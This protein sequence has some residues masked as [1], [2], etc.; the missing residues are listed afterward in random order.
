MNRI[1]LVVAAL[2]LGAMVGGS[3]VYEAVP[4]REP[5]SC[6]RVRAITDDYLYAQAALVSAMGKREAASDFVARGEADKEVTAAL[7]ELES[8]AVGYDDLFEACEASS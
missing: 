6:Q 1:A 5:T 3:L 7:S 4:V 8:V 2:I